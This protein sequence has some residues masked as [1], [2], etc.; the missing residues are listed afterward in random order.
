MSQQAPALAPVISAASAV[1]EIGG[2][3]FERDAPAFAIAV[4]Q[5]H[6]C[7]QRLRC[8]CQPNGVEMYVARL[9]PPQAGYAIKRMPDTGWHHAPACPSYAPAAELSGL[10]QVFGSA[11]AEDPATGETTLT[12]DFALTKIAGRMSPTPSDTVMSSASATGIRLSLRGLLHYLWD[13][14]ELTRWHP[15]FS[16]KRS[17]GTVRRLLLA[18]VEHMR[19]GGDPLRLRLYIPE[20]FSL[21]QRAAINERRLA[22][23]SRAV[24]R[25][26]GAWP[27]MLLVAEV[28][29]FVPSRYGY[30]AVIKHLPDQGL[31]LDEQLYKRLERSFEPDLAVWAASADIRMVMIATFG[32]SGAGVAS[33]H[34]LCLMP[35]S[36]Q[37]LP[38]GDGFGQQLIDKLVAEDRVFTRSL[39]YNLSPKEPLAFAV[40]SDCGPDAVTLRLTYE[41]QTGSRV[42]STSEEGENS[43]SWIWRP[44]LEPLPRL[45]APQ[46]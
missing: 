18:A 41:H 17:W 24:A 34:E 32:L 31:M 6:A 10:G 16:G 2:Q 11:I 43:A 8:L 19:V 12:L 13:E 23:W 25:P 26:K 30:K 37:W 42:P 7:H 36:V 33:I 46:R 3:R 14:A 1:Y 22:E 9:A 15:A 20:P 45:P 21:E 38:V 5:A 44:E 4:A 35:V 29:E 40:L 28:K 39:P 27:L